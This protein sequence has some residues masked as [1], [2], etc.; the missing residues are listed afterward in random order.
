[1]SETVSAKRRITEW[2]SRLLLIVE[3]RTVLDNVITSLDS[4]LWWQNLAK[5]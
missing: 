5:W 1:M 2:T 3:T 4:L